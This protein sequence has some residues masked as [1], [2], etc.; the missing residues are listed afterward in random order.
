LRFRDLPRKK[1]LT[2]KVPADID[3]LIR[4]RAHEQGKSISEF[5]SAA[6]YRGLGQKLP[7]AEN[8]RRRE[9]SPAGR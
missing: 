6:L 2:V 5:A 8:G 9:P 4:D 3:K 7:W 1:V